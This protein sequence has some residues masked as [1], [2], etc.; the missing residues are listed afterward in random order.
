MEVVVGGQCA[1]A[2]AGVLLALCCAAAGNWKLDAVAA[3]F[4]VGA[5][6]VAVDD[7]DVDAV[8]DD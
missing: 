3:V 1:V 4:A 2:A 5:V 7:D 8:V 6:T